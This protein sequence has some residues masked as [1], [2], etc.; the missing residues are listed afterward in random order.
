M[1]NADH[2]VATSSSRPAHH[3]VIAATFTAEP[4]REAI[5]FWMEELNTTASIEFAPYNQVFQVLLDPDS[6]LARNRKGINILLVRLE[7]WQRFHRE[8]TGAENPEECLAENAAVLIESVRAAT[9]RLPTRLILSFCP[10]SPAACNEPTTCDLLTRWEERIASALQGTPGLCVVRSRDLEYYPVAE[11]Y[12]PERDQLGHIPYTPLFF[13]A[14]ATVLARRVHA[15]LYPPCKVVVVDCDNTLWQ[16][17]VGEDGVAGISIPPAWSQ[18]QQFLVELSAKGF[19][20]ALCSKNEE[21]DVL[22]VFAQRQDMVLKKEHLVSWRI[23]WQRKS[24]NLKSLAS[25]LNV[26]LDSFVFL[27][28]NPVECAE[29]QAECPD[30]LALRLPVEDDLVHF[31]KHVWAFDHLS[32]TS[33]D[34]QRTAMYKQEIERARFQKQTLTIEEYLAGLDVRVKIYAPEACHLSRIAQLTQRTN[35]FNF[36][37]RRRADS[38]IGQL[39]E[40]ELECLAVEVADRFGDYGL[41]GALIFTEQANALEIDTFLLSCRVLGRGVEHRMLNKLGA[42]ASERQLPQIRATLLVTKKNQPARDFL[43]SVAAAWRQE[44]SGGWRYDIPAEC[45]ACAVYSPKTND[46]EIEEGP[47][48]TENT[49]QGSELR[50]RSERAERIARMLSVP[51]QVL[52][53]LA[54]RSG[55][56]RSRAA[57]ASPFVA[58]QTEIEEALAVIWAEVLQFDSVGRYDN[59]FELG[60]TSMVS[61]DLFARVKQRFL[62]RL[63]LTSLIEAPTIAQLARLLDGTV[64]RGSLVPISH[65][66]SKSPLFLVH[67]GDGETMLYRNL[68]ILLKADRPVFGLQPHSQQNAPITHT[69]IP[70]MAAYYVKQIQSVQLHGPYLVGGMCAGGVIAFEAARQLQK[71]GHEVMLVALIDAADPAAPPKVRRTIRLRARGFLSI[72]HH[73]ESVRF[74]RRMGS[75]LAQA[76]RKIRNSVAY[77]LKRRVQNLRSAVQMRLFRL[78]LD[79]GFKLPPMLQQIPVRTAYLYAEKSY[80]P[81]GP[82]EGELVLFRAMHGTGVDEP[83]LERYD[84]PLFGWGKRATQGVRTYDVPGGHSSMLQE[85]HVQT[86]AACIQSYIND[87]LGDEPV[88]N[89]LTDGTRNLVFTAGVV[90]EMNTVP[91]PT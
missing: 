4:L 85:P 65:G 2:S 26:H 67:D 15:L 37:T 75:I 81:Q 11:Y 41:V 78:Y 38:E 30:V 68:A 9:S 66:G 48:A 72:F 7:D 54:A 19:L 31:L 90:Q 27:D 14:L 43:D 77:E 42:I 73:G 47:V 88:H 87:V 63:P 34:Q 24:L 89:R 17:T 46:G 86:L 22:D 35:Q 33:E 28:D 91:S 82:F 62:K 20:L 50:T 29:V 52:G 53:L 18:L 60:G 74:D 16:G 23:N 59:F 80:Q 1:N 40:L 44:I 45:A 57:L 83:Y 71:L 49:S 61:V 3:F 25:E 69:R 51:E 55:C 64:A 8:P 32:V 13:V 39:A 76:V 58:P 84:D 56:K 70:D 10:S 6:V 79:R 5:E 12:D 21:S 36:T